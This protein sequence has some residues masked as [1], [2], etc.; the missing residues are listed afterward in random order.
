MKLTRQLRSGPVLTTH[1]KAIEANTKTFLDAVNPGDIERS[2]DALAKSTPHIMAVV[3]GDGYGHGYTWVA[4]AALNAGATW[5]GVTSFAEAQ[6]LRE[7]G[8]THTPIL[9]WLNSIEVDAKDSVELGVDI[10]IPG[11]EHLKSFLATCA[12]PEK[13]K[14]ERRA[15][16]HL[17]FDMGM[18]RDGCAEEYWQTLIQEAA[19]AHNDGLISVVGLMSH[20]RNSGEKDLEDNA[21]AVKKMLK[22][23]A[24]AKAVDLHPE[25]THL[26]AT[27]AALTDPTTHFDM[28]RIGA[29]LVGIDPSETLNLI[30]ASTL[31]APVI[32]HRRISRGETV[33]Y[34]R[35][36]TAPADT[37]LALIPVGYADAILRKIPSTAGVQ[38]A[39]KRFNIVGRVS[40]DQVVI[41]TGDWEVPLGEVA[42]IWG[43]GTDSEPTIHDW[44]IWEDT[45]AHEVVTTIGPRIARAVTD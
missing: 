25:I 19:K 2:H 38:I 7:G 12:P 15:R 4:E 32:Q 3:K 43:P 13:N 27:G 26:A 40:M 17:Q 22:V 11:L 18:A 41:E 9:S 30:G 5:L 33:G 21:L 37:N 20:L 35:T 44:A 45:I 34:S 31:T 36:W 14:S 28:V 29:G 39:G 10:A 24:L 8:I 16:I 42:T 1:T 23:R 6:I